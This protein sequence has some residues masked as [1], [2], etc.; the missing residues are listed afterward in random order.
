MHAGNSS[1]ANLATLK[2]NFCDIYHNGDN[3]L[4]AADARCGEASNK[5]VLITGGRGR[6]LVR[7]IPL[8][9]ASPGRIALF[10]MAITSVWPRP[11]YP[12]YPRRA[13]RLSDSPD[14]RAVL[15]YAE[16]G[17][18]PALSGVFFLSARKSCG[19]S[20]KGSL[21]NVRHEQPIGHPLLEMLSSHR[22]SLLPFAVVF[23]SPGRG[24]RPKQEAVRPSLARSS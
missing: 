13:G 2:S 1:W 3:F 12:F 9:I 16:H 23:W 7:R 17:T 20:A 18:C 4:R 19:P 10:V 22:P 5:L 24:G 15:T 21:R 6:G 11:P 14:P 8:N